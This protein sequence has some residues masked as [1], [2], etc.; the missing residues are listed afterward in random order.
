MELDL[1][2]LD[3]LANAATPGPWILG[4]LESW[5]EDGVPIRYVYRTPR[6]THRT[7][8]RVISGEDDQGRKLDCDSDAAFIAAAHP[9]VV[10]ELVR[11][12]REAEA[13]TAAA[14][15]VLAERRR[16]IEAEGWT[17]DRDDEHTRFELARAGACYAEY[18]NWPAHSEIPPNSWPWPAAWWKPTNYRR[19]L[20]KAAALILAEIER[21]DRLQP[22]RG[23]G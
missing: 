21:L 2:E 20:V 14:R 9:A 5:D 7:R 10:L 4:R 13:T 19:N 17:L 12:L 1:N 23:E 22:P 15:D 16:Q 3:R 18:G 8:M 11:R 6:E